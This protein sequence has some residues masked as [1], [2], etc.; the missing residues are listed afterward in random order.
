MEQT[1]DE[2][3]DE[4]SKNLEMSVTQGIEQQMA[5]IMEKKKMERE[6]LSQGSTFS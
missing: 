4:R 2:N 1:E 3:K 6:V 5:E